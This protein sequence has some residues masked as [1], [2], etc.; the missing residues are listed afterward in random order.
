MA[1][2]SSLHN[3]PL[4]YSKLVLVDFAH[5][6]S[7]KRRSP[8]C[9]LQTII[10]PTESTKYLGV[11]FDQNLSWKQQ[12][13]HMIGK[14]TKW[15]MQIRRL[16]K[17][18]WGLTLGNTRQLYIS[19]AVP[20]IIYVIDVWCTPPYT[21][22][23]QQRGTVRITGKVAT[24]QRAGMLAITGGLRTSPTDALNAAAYLLP[25][26]LLVDKACYRAVI[27]LAMLP[28]SHP[29]HKIA[30]YKT[31]GKIKQHKSPMNSLLAAYS[32]NPKKIEKILAAARDPTLQG[33]LPFITSIADSREDSIKEAE[34]ASKEVQVF[35]DGSAL[36]RKVGAVTCDDVPGAC[37][38]RLYGSM[39][40]QSN[41]NTSSTAWTDL[42]ETISNEKIRLPTNA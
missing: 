5:R 13:A 9:L 25:I 16:A 7:S 20:R 34:S 8:L 3:S 28:K 11:I 19:I 40:K 10:Q 33:K 21:N 2:W 12:H 14:G 39:E 37:P 41:A 1:E 17:P 32:F 30:N 18:S 36:N 26:L 35:T 24:V 42:G 29:L 31:S 38:D 4:E 22:G 15:A 6:H 23:Q 27:C